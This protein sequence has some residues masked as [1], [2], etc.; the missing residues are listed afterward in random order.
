MKKIINILVII[1]LVSIVFSF[2]VPNFTYAKVSE[3]SVN[4][5]KPKGT[6]GED[7]Q[8]LE[9]KAGNILGI[10]SV[11]GTI[12]SV[13]ALMALGIKYMIG[14]IE[15]K[16]EYKKDFIP[17]IIGAILVFAGS[18]VPQFIYNIMKSFK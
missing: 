9:D 4:K 14:S 3:I 2:I 18:Q 10:L 15:E 5:Y 13:V 12:V 16:A 6:S 11:V 7:T 1:T 8:V 17:Y